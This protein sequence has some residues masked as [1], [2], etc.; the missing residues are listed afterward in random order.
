VAVTK[1]DR[2]TKATEHLSAALEPFVNV[3]VAADTDRLRE[4]VCSLGCYRRS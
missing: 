2:I 4:L 3:F 1:R